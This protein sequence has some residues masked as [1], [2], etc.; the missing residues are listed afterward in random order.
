MGSM[1]INIRTLLLSLL[2]S[3]TFIAPSTNAQSSNVNSKN[4]ITRPFLGQTITAGQAFDIVWQNL[5][6]DVV[7]LYLV[8]GPPSTE[9]VSTIANEI[10]NTGL[11]TWDVPSSLSPSEDYKIR[12]IVGSDEGSIKTSDFFTIKIASTTTSP[13]ASTVT[14]PSFTV[15][16]PTAIMSGQPA[17]C[18]GWRFVQGNDNCNNLVTRFQDINLTLEKLL[19]WNPTLG[20]D[21]SGLTPRYYI[22]VQIFG[23]NA[24]GTLSVPQ[25]PLTSPTSSQ[26]QTSTVPAAST[27]SNTSPPNQSS[28]PPSDNSN[29]RTSIIVGSVIGGM[30]L[31]IGGV[32]LGIWMVVRERRKRA[33]LQFAPLA[34]S[35]HQKPE[36]EAT[37]YH[38][39]RE[40]SEL[41]SSSNLTPRVRESR[42][43]A[44]NFWHKDNHNA[45]YPA[46][47]Q[48]N[49]SQSPLELE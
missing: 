15:T 42:G 11:F 38:S 36:L 17:N 46:H 49:P 41:E 47:P 33:A 5:V 44:W 1:A 21:C 24:S 20:R 8:E 26:M 19:E 28:S 13:P 16:A 22:C 27:S 12:I 6:G 34:K 37:Q 35:E 30:A 32:L 14:A 45:V 29:N 18:I 23:S 25:A 10:N 3:I 48:F 40:P 39:P 31:V 7:T 4:Q 9:T 2:L 43:R